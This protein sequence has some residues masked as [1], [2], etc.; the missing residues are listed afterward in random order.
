MVVLN[1][2]VFFTWLVIQDR[3]QTSGSGIIG[4]CPLV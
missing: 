2:L 4:T 3:W 1:D